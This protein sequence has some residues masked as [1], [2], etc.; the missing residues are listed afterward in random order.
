MLGGYD[1]S[2]VSQKIYQ[3]CCDLIESCG[4][5]SESV[6]ASIEEI[7]SGYGLVLK[8]PNLFAATDRLMSDLI[9]T[10]FQICI[11][12][13]YAIDYDFV[14][15]ADYFLSLVQIYKTIPTASDV[16]VEECFDS[17]YSIA[18]LDVSG[19]SLESKTFVLLNKILVNFMVNKDNVRIKILVDLLVRAIVVKE[20][21]ESIE[22]E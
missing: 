7:V 19:F 3:L 21:S 20:R 17:I 2:K 8:N 12:K 10:L 4:V 6:N 14:K 16:D 11:S 5:A 9:Y 18:T 15:K 22:R 1:V 13:E